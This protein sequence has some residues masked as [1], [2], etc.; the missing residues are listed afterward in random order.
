MTQPLALIAYEKLLPGT[1]VANRLRDLNY[2]VQ[3]VPIGHDLVK[4]ALESRPLV[5][6][7]DLYSQ[8]SDACSAIAELRNT[9]ETKHIPIIAFASD[10]DSGLQDAARAAGATLVTAD[11]TI[12]PHLEQ[13]LERALNVE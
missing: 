2:R 3:V 11:T 4:K 9:S 12:L 8:A 6:L 10:A 1:Q 13:F 5:V 7:V